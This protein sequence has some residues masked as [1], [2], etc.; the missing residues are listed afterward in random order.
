MTDEIESIF[1]IG[2]KVQRTSEQHTEPEWA[3]EVIGYVQAGTDARAVL[4]EMGHKRS[5]LAAPTGSHNS[6]EDTG[7]HCKQD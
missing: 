6:K 2:T 4:K 3:G 1:P 7:S 5:L